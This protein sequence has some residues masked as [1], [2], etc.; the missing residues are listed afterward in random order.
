MPDEISAEDLAAIVEQIDRGQD[1]FQVPEDLLEEPDTPV[2]P[3]EQVD[4]SLFMKI[5]R[6]TVGER[7]KLALKGN[8]DARSILMRDTNRLIPKLVL[9]NPRISD[10]EI[11][12]LGRNR[13]ADTELLRMVGEDREWS[14]NP[15]IRSA[16]VTNPKTPV[17]VA[18]K[19]IKFLPERELR[20]LAKSKNITSAVATAAKRTLFLKTEKR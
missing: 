18:L 1:S 17:T 9:Q 3:P 6:M 11:I 7:I 5:M 13:N 4:Q 2:P 8:R 10:D 12:A 16:L 19:F 14:Q 20:Q 15:Q